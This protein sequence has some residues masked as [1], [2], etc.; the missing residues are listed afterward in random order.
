MHA[1]YV[2]STLRVLG[3]RKLCVY[4]NPPN[5]IAKFILVFLF[6]FARYVSHAAVAQ[7][8]RALFSIAHNIAT[9]NVKFVGS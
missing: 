9:H 8:L 3:K 7:M 1:I 4:Q 6:M 5:G 2:F